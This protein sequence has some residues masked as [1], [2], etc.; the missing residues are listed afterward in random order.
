MKCARCG[1]PRAQNR[2]ELRA[3]ADGRRKRSRYLCDTHDAE[4]N[5]VAMTFLGITDADRKASEYSAAM[6]KERA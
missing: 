5:R 1:E 3:C 4:L 6:E 2:W